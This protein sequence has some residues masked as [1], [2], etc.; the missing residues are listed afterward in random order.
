MRSRE[1]CSKCNGTGWEAEPTYVRVPEFL[2]D[3]V[4]TE[5]LVRVVPGEGRRTKCDACE[6]R[7]W[8]LCERG[9]LL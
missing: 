9:V 1:R 2:D 8:L 6:G 3:V 4:V 5:R 7:G